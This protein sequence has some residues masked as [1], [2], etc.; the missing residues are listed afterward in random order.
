MTKKQAIRSFPYPGKSASFGFTMVE[1]LVVILIIV[2]LAALS[3]VGVNR[4][5][6]ASNRASSIG[7]LRQLGIGITTF[8]ADNNGYLPLSR[9]GSVFWP[10]VIYPYVPS[11]AVFLRPGSKNLPMS[12]SQP[13]GYFGGVDAKT[14]EGVPIRWNYAINGGHVKLPF[15]EDDKNP[16]YARGL[17][18]SMSTVKQPNRTVFMSDGSGW[19]LNG[20]AKPDS[21]R[22]YRWKNATT[23]VLFGDGSTRNL[24]CKTDLIASQF[25][26]D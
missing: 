9:V 7:N 11:P 10:E 12:A 15:S 21:K 16:L 20:E 25:L 14:P 8:T 1:L 17:A 2:V 24:N 3:F 19:W 5:R 4:I 26:V 23:N 6:D 22:M 18:R 13:D